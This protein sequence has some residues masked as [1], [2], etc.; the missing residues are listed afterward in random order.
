MPLGRLLLVLL[1]LALPT[2]GHALTLG[3][4]LEW[5]AVASGLDR[6]TA[7]RF[8]PDGRLFILEKP[9]RVRVW[10][11]ETGLLAVP[12]LT[13][14]SCDG[15]EMGLLGLAFDPD[16]ATN[17]HLYLYHTQPPGGAVDR[18]ASVAGR[19][20][21]VVRVT[22]SGDTV[23]PAT[24]AVLFDGIRTDNGNHDGGD[25]AL[26][27]D[28]HLYVAVG[29]TGSGDRGTPGEATN[30]YAR[31][32]TSPNG[33]ILRLTR[34]G[35]PAPG[36]PFAHLGGAAASVFALGLRNPWRIVFE[37]GTDLLWVADVGQN[38]WEEIDVVRA[39]D[40][41]GWPRCEGREPGGSCPA[42][43]VP[44]VFVYGHRASGASV[45]GGAFWEGAA[46]G[47]RPRTS[48]V[49][50]DFVFDLLWRAVPSAASDGFESQPEVIG[51]EAGGPVDFTVGPDGA[52]YYVAYVDEEV[53]RIASGGGGEVDACGRKLGRATQ[54]WL[55]R[56]TPLV[57]GCVRGGDACLPPS[58][59]LLAPA[60][61]R[62]TRAISRRCSAPPPALCARL[63]CAACASP[64][65]LAACVA[66]GGGVVAPLAAQAFTGGADSCHHAVFKAG[67]DLAIARGRALARC[68][69]RGRTDCPAAPASSPRLAAALARRCAAPPADLCAAFDC[70]SCGDAAALA[71][72]AA[73]A[74]TSAVD[75]FA[76]RVYGR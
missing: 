23:D 40:D 48:Y 13:I 56:A 43:T 37:P 38:A 55:R 21:R 68:A 69:A 45:T 46:G 51:R 8:A 30:P 63:G 50:G 47:V 65:D 62:L 70:A 44:P 22:V 32:P 12:A 59:A 25:L 1:A 33:K 27:P 3:R 41:L 64:A 60:T 16:F 74:V 9:G 67:L 29:D 61:A 11:P 58:A 4:G 39:G 66:G 57:A 76:F 26:G 7:A 35:A 31:D 49:F 42:G 17:G 10:R 24:L 6:P 53:R 2:G 36:N 54:A 20:N 28:G 72:C 52:L 18:C 14:P 73:A 19:E 5:S 71:S 15:S 34:T 75:G